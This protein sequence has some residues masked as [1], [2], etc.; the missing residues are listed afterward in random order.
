MEKVSTIGLD[1]A[2][3]V[4]TAWTRRARWLSAGSCV[5]M[6]SSRRAR[7]ALEVNSVPCRKRSCRACR[8]GRSARQLARHAAVRDRGVGDHGKAFARHLV[9]NVEHAETTAACP[10]TNARWASLPPGSAPAYR[11]R[12]AVTLACAPSPLPR[13]RGDRCG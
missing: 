10:S 6:I 2:K 13:G 12:A 9:N 8:G 4:R 5:V 3:H 1:V 7:M 11:Q